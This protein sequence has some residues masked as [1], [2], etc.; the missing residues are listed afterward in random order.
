MND[1]LSVGRFRGTGAR[2]T[3]AGGRYFT[4]VVDGSNEVCDWSA[5]AG[6]ARVTG[7]ELGW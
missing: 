6:D 3:F 5:A 7:A 2:A 1:V 4:V